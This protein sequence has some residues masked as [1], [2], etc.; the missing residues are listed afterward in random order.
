MGCSFFNCN[1]FHNI[2]RPFNG[3]NC[4]TT[5][6]LRLRKLGNIGKISQNYCLVISDSPEI[7]ML[8]ELAKI[9]EKQKLNLSRSALFHI[10]KTRV[11]LK[12]IVNDCI[13][14]KLS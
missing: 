14:G 4:Q 1:H 13:S 2:L 12:Y 7:K 9:S 11:C 10:K 3:S 6:S 8:S 5:G